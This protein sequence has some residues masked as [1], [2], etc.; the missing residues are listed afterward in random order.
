MPQRRERGC[1]EAD[2]VLLS[3]RYLTEFDIREAGDHSL[4]AGADRRSWLDNGGVRPICWKEAAA[5]ENKQLFLAKRSFFRKF[6][7]S[8][9]RAPGVGRKRLPRAIRGNG[10]ARFCLSKFFPCT[11]KRTGVRLYFGC[12]RR[13]PMLPD[14]LNPT[15]P[16]LRHFGLDHGLSPAQNSPRNPRLCPPTGRATSCPKY[17][18]LDIRTVPTQWLTADCKIWN[19]PHDPYL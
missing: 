13:A 16:N 9:S 2:T 17:R 12:R 5:E 14:W 18:R 7:S 8:I 10:R 19:K 6:K 1:F 11:G 3:M 15:P 4:D